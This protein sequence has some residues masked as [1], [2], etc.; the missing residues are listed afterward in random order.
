MPAS[1]S[2]D[3]VRAV[4]STVLAPYLGKTMAES[5]ARLYV[6]RL[7]PTATRVGAEDVERLVGWI[8]PGLKVFLGVQRAAQ[9]LAELREAL[10]KTVGGP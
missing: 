1:A 10:G 4:I 6:E 8:G 9:V 2:L 5:S 3:D 7:G